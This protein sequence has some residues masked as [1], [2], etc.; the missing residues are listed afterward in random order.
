MAIIY[1]DL[2]ECL[3]ELSAEFVREDRVEIETTRY[4]ESAMARTPKGPEK[5]FYLSPVYKF[6]HLTLGLQT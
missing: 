5:C 3:I 4:S 1:L 2:T 6:S